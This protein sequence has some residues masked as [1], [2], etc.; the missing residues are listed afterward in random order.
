MRHCS[1]EL[2]EVTRPRAEAEAQSGLYK[3]MLQ[4]TEDVDALRALHVLALYTSLASSLSVTSPGDVNTGYGNDLLIASALR[5]ARNMHLRSE[6]QVVL[7]FRAGISTS[8][9]H[10]TAPQNVLG[11]LAKCRLVSPSYSIRGLQSAYLC[12]SYLALAALFPVHHRKFVSDS[13]FVTKSCQG[14]P[15]RTS[16]QIGKGRKPDA[17]EELKQAGSIFGSPHILLAT[18]RG[19]PDARLVLLSQLCHITFRAFEVPVPTNIGEFPAAMRGVMSR[20]ELWLQD[21]IP[22]RGASSFS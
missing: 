7:D 21:F 14:L 8:H 12:H 9:K 20:L 18:S 13:A 2:R 5:L 19:V 11:S 6:M 10:A 17:P 4:G 3:T 16:I 15:G 1:P 22:Y